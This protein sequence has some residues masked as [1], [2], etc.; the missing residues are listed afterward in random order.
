ML[1]FSVSWIK[2][3]ERFN[4]HLGVTR[5]IFATLCGAAKLRVE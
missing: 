3:F 2:P 5:N 4:G 1:L